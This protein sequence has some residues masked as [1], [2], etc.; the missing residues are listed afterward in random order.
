M[1]EAENEA[2]Q[3]VEDLGLTLPICPEEV[4]EHISDETLKVKYSD[5]P[6]DSPDICGLS[7]GNGGEIQVV[8]NSNIS[9]RS[10]R[11][12][13]AAHE[14]GHVV[15]HIMKGIESKFSCTNSDLY[16]KDGT[17]R[18]REVE[19]NEFASSLLMPKSIIKSKVFR[20]DLS[21]NLIQE[22]ADECDTSLE[23]TAR[24]VVSISN[25]RCALIIHRKGEMW[26]PIRSRSFIGFVDSMPFPR[27]LESYPDDPLAGYPDYLNECDTSD[28]LSDIRNIP[29][30]MQ[31]CSIYNAEYDR[32][33]TLLVVPE[34]E[35]AEIDEDWEEPLFSR[36]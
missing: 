29:Q 5:K 24:R 14:V 4:C 20:N 31:Y 35:F 25:E 1:T 16:A 19:A 28:W 12:F 17:N 33:M 32:R 18:R 13:T 30:L 26:T 10:R 3:L 6:F 11:N 8:V 21:W 36:N 22:L 34:E 7:I 2:E 27:N 15:L 9:Y 23:A